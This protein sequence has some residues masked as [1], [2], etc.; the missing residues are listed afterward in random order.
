M[1][2]S[3]RINVVLPE[4]A[5]QVLDRVTTKGSRSRLFSDA[6]LHDVSVQ[7][8]NHLAERL[9]AGAVATADRDLGIAEEWF[10]LEG[11]VAGHAG[12]GAKSQKVVT[13]R[14]GEI[15]SVNFDPTLG[16]EIRKPRPALVIQNEI[17]KRVPSAVVLNQIRSVDRQRL[18]KRVGK[19][20]QET[21][22][23]VN[24]AIRISLGLVEF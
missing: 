12:P 11:G 4:A 15:Y 23:R 7:G 5:M 18:V 19:A 8:R 22:R 24:R 10:P 21:M 2:L 6:V 17:S 20:R 14:R 3:V 13:P 1:S 9:K 16:A